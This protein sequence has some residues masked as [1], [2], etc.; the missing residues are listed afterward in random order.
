MTHPIHYRT[1]AA[2]GVEIFYREAGPDDAPALLLLHGYPTSSHMFRNLIP[3]LSGRYRVI[4]PDLPGFGSTK[5]PPR[6]EY[7]YTFDRLAR[8][9]DAFTKQLRLERYALYV[10]DYE[11][12]TGFRLAAANPDK[13][14]A[15]ISRMATPT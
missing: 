4:A 9:I 15:I 14:T 6:G 12:P 10:F 3:A 8:S 1:R 2:D 13:I 7:S 11:A 5:V